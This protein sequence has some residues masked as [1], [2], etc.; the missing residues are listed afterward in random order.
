ME[1]LSCRMCQ[2]LCKKRKIVLQSILKSQDRL[3]KNLA[4][5]WLTSVSQKFRSQFTLAQKKRISS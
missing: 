5:G 4:E 2:A 1:M 3:D